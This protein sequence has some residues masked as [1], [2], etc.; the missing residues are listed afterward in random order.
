M[1]HYGFFNGDAEYGQEEF[2]RYFD[3]IY[4]S[5]IAVN[6]DETMSYAVT[7]GTN[8]VSVGAGFAILKGFYHYNDSARVLTLTPDAN[9]P[10]IYR[11]IV[12]LDIAQG[13][14]ALVA[15]AG[16]ASSS[17]QPPA[18]TR[19]ATVYELSLGQYRIERSGAVS[20]VR[21]ER[22]DVNLCGAIRPKNLSEY[23]AAMKENQRLWEEWFEAQQ[24]TAQRNIYVQADAPGEAVS[25]SIWI[26]T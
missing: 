25:G 5:G 13:K 10:K 2:N 26:D 19:N 9:L 12:Q 17:P 23:D 24:G 16:T 15:R 20:L 18:L 8:Q 11:I 1:E 21:D 22:P 7:A 6:E 3:Y 14:T 4:E